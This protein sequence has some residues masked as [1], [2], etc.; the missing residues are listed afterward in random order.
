MNLGYE[1]D[2][3]GRLRRQSEAAGADFAASAA[4][5]ENFRLLLHGEVAR[6]YL[7]LPVLDRESALL[8]RTLELRQENLRLLI[9]SPA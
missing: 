9:S 2:L 6:A 8:E 5:V 7:E 1:L 4:E 3:W